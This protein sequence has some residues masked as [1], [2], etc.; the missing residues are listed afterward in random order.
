MTDKKQQAAVTCDTNAGDLE[1]AMTEVAYASRLAAK[2]KARAGTVPTHAYG[3]EWILFD[4]E[5]KQPKA[6]MFFEHGREQGKD[7]PYLARASRIVA[8]GRMAMI[9]GLPLIVVVLSGK[10]T[11][12]AS[13]NKEAVART[14]ANTYAVRERGGTHELWLEVPA[15]LLKEFKGEK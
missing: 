1:H 8:G 15:D 14:I 9:L 10:E 12:F 6:L 7:A 3:V 11:R 2:W 4:P 13:L 5:S